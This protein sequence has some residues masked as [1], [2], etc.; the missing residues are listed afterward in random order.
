MYYLGTLIKDLGK[1]CFEINKIE[2][3]DIIEKISNFI[4]T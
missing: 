2:D 4:K 1:K 3:L